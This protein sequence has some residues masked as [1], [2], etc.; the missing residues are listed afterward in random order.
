M[1]L[2]AEVLREM[3]KRI[4]FTFNY[5]NVRY[6]QD[7]SFQRFGIIPRFH[8]FEHG[9]NM[10]HLQCFGLLPRDAAGAPD[11]VFDLDK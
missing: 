1:D 10:L 11:G 4:Y 6:F 7:A 9:F 3:T 8:D 2:K 5:K